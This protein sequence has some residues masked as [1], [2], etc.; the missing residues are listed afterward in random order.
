MQIRSTGAR[1]ATG[2]IDNGDGTYSIVFTNAGQSPSFKL[3][4]GPPIALDVGLLQ[5][6]VTFDAATGDFISFDVVKEAG[7]RPPACD[8]IIAALT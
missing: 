7:Q 1:R 5:G 4:N 8:A 2:E 6:V 3:E